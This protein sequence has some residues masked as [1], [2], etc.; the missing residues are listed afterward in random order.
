[1]GITFLRAVV[2]FRKDD[3]KKVGL[4]REEDVEKGPW[5]GRFRSSDK[6]FAELAMV[7]RFISIYPRQTAAHHAPNS[8]R[9]SYV[10]PLGH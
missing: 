7:P 6:L 4:L 1:M 5:C 10:G 3:A 8:L 9:G 2:R